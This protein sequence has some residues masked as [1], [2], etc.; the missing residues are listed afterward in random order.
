MKMLRI[1]HGLLPLLAA[2]AIIVCL[3]ARAQVPSEVADHVQ[4]ARTQIPSVSHEE[5]VKEGKWS[6]PTFNQ[7]RSDFTVDL[8]LVE[9]VKNLPGNAKEAFDVIWPEGNGTEHLDPYSISIRLQLKNV[10]IVE[11]FQ[12]MNL[13]FE[14]SSTPV[15]W[16]LVMNGERPT[17]VLKILP[18]AKPPTAVKRT[19]VVY[20][21]DLVANRDT[22]SFATE[23]SKIKDA[24]DVTVFQAG[25]GNITIMSYRD[26]ELLIITGAEEQIALAREVLSALAQK[27]AFEGAPLHPQTP[28][29]A[30]RGPLPQPQSLPAP[31]APRQQ[32]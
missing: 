29:R 13:Q 31:P 32:N 16:A 4:A 8:P 30:L 26:G 3:P 7:R 2:S 11:A 18:Q 12:A 21:G 27:A 25:L 24:I 15:R 19:A 22:N 23:I 1:S 20:V 9:A 10:S 6:D 17:A 28:E 14:L 5:I